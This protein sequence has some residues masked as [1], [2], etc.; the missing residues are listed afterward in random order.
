MNAK[1]VLLAVL[2]HPDD[3]TFGM[4]GTLALYAQRGVDVH[5]VC[6]T[7]GEVGEVAPE[8]LTGYAS[9]AERRMDELSCAA[10]ILGLRKVHFLDYRDSGMAGSADNQH[11]RALAAAPVEEVAAKVARYIRQLQPQVVLTSDPIGGYMH[12]DHIACHKATVRAIELAASPGFETG[13]PPFQAQKLYFNVF[14]KGVL[15]FALRLLPLFGMDPHKFGRNGDIDLA[16]IVAQGE[17]PIH[18]TIDITTVQEIRERATACHTSQ[19]DGMPRRGPTGWLMRWFN[20]KDH[21]MRAIPPG[22]E[23]AL[24]RD[25]F[26]GI[27]TADVKPLPQSG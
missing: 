5:L 27:P 3:E 10:E 24:E 16:A 12:P 6:A 11:P 9:I 2:A 14:P 4:G 18:A 8:L 26:A 22:D 17:F 1:R 25:L 7:R 21:Y 15:R 19:L 20:R 13:L 23:R